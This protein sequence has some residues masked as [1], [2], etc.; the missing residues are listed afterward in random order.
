MSQENVEVIIRAMEAYRAGGFPA[1]R[2]FLHPDFEMVR[3]GIHFTESGTYR[4]LEAASKSMLDYIGAFE[5]YRAEPEEFIDAG[6]HVVVA[7]TEVGRARTSSVELSERWYAVFT[8]RDGK[9]LRLQWF[10]ERGHALEA[11]GLRQ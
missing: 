9:I 3:S 10:D 7:Q 2:D 6:D 11:A 1:G 4:G 5:D 8:L